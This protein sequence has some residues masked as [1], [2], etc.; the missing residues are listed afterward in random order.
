[1]NRYIQLI[2]QA[3]DRAANKD[4]GLKKARTI[5]KLAKQVAKKSEEDYDKRKVNYNLSTPKRFMI[6]E[7]KKKAGKKA[8]KEATEVNK[9]MYSTDETKNKLGNLL[10]RKSILLND[11]TTSP[12]AITRINKEIDALIGKQTKQQELE[13]ELEK[14]KDKPTVYL[15][16]LQEAKAEQEKELA[17]DKLKQQES[18]SREILNKQLLALKSSEDLSTSQLEELQNLTEQLEGIPNALSELKDL[19]KLNLSPEKLLNLDPKFKKLPAKERQSLIDNLQKLTP[20]QTEQRRQLIETWVKGTPAQKEMYRKLMEAEVKRKAEEQAEEKRRKEEE[21]RIKEE[22]KRLKKE[23]QAEEKRRKKEEK[24]SKTKKSNDIDALKEQILNDTAFRDQDIADY[25]KDKLMADNRQTDDMTIRE[26]I[27]FYE[28]AYDTEQLK[29][30]ILLSTNFGGDNKMKN[31]V[32]ERLLDQIGPNTR[33]DI[34]SLIDKLKTRYGHDQD[35][36]QQQDEDERELQQFQQNLTPGEKQFQDN[37][38]KSI[39]QELVNDGNDQEES[40]EDA[41]EVIKNT[42]KAL[43]KRGQRGPDKKP[44]IRSTKAQIKLRKQQQ[45]QVQPQQ[46]Q[47]QQPTTQNVNDVDDALNMYNDELDKANIDRQQI[48]TQLLAIPGTMT[49]PQ[50]LDQIDGMINTAKLSNQSNMSD[51]GEGFKPL[52]SY[53]PHLIAGALGENIDKVRRKRFLI[54]LNKEK[55]FKNTESKEYAEGLK[56]HLL[57]GGTVSGY[58]GMGI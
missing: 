46:L 20:R 12:E 25:V 6:S 55:L 43:R 37:L 13:K 48:R 26:A 36:A 50:I 16:K 38:Q 28:N 22:E 3:H 58:M 34:A 23:E 24:S 5:S 14:Y 54:N 51:E 41:K 39:E 7:A 35:A 47:P 53:P 9:F 42:Y 15:A 32:A 45:Q 10:Y 40:E 27:S 29:K 17:Q 49:Y 11:P 57:R 31:Y 21:K 8:F 44:R 56:Q 2:A 4:D 19:F 30:E 1:M 18:L 52:S 33:N